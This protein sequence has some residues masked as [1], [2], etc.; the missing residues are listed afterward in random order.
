MS[1]LTESR[2]RFLAQFASTSL[3]ATL[4]PGVLWARMQ[5]AGAQR[6]TLEM[7][8]DALKLSGVELSED[9]RKGLLESANRN[10]SGFE[11]IRRLTI[12]PDVSPPFHFSPVVPGVRI[13][14]AQYPIRLS[15]VSGVKRPDDLEDVAFWPVRHLAELI[16]SRQVSSLELTEMYLRRLHRD[17]GTLNNVVTFLDEYGR[18]EAKRADAEIAAGKYRGPLHGIPWGVKDIFTVKGIRT[19]WGST[20]FKD[21]VFDYDAT[22]VEQLRDAGAVLIAKLTTGQL[23]NGDRWFG[24]QT[25]SPWDPSR[26]SSGSSSGSASATAAGGVAFAIGTETNGSILTPSAQCGVTGLR[27]TFGRVS[28][29]GVMTLT[30]TMDRVGPLCRYAEDCALIMQA[31]SRPDGRD[32]SVVDLP[33]NWDAQLDIRKLRVGI[34]QE[35]FDEITDPVL[36]AN[37]DRTLETLRA[38]GVRQLTPVRPLDFSTNVNGRD[39]EFAAAFDV[40]TRA[41]RMKTTNRAIPAVNGRLIPAAE[42]LQQ[43]RAR[44][45]MMMELAKATSH[46]DVYVV[47][48]KYVGAGTPPPSPAAA[49]PPRPQ[50]PAPDSALDR[51]ALHAN[52]AGYPAVNL[53][54]G[55]TEDGNPTNIAIYAPPFREAQVLA[56]AKAYQDVARF[57]VRIPTRQNT[58][59]S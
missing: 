14:K 13:D 7:L 29:Y 40:H 41:G 3:G 52:L 35:T 30:W 44:T 42:Y 11:A 28:R 55:F 51:H 21:Q 15:R 53:P 8:T 24:G 46:V 33:W 57:H 23:A 31:I 19:T 36:R 17:N 50:P 16:R 18:A 27:P 38:L 39:A 32:M 9:E 20:P 6:V 5:D 4:L 1:T 22:V 37:A 54:N 43:Q 56:L 47:G 58:P 59:T 49:T 48:S 12:P 2:R 25:R 34:V 45:L 10:L 26:G